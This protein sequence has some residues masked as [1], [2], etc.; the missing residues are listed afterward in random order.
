LRVTSRG[1]G[2]VYKRQPETELGNFSTRPLGLGVQGLADVYFKLGIPYDSKE[3]EKIN[4]EIFETLY[5]G[6]IKGSINE[7]KKD[8]SYPLYKDS[9]FSQGKFQ[10]DLASEFDGIDLNNYLSGRWDWDL[11]KQECCRYGIRNSMLVALMPTASSAQILNN[12]DCFEPIDANIYK[13]RTLSGDQL[14]MNKYLVNDLDKLGLWSKDMKDLILLHKGS[15]QQIDN[16]PKKLKDVYKTCW[17]ISMKAVIKQ[18]SDRGVFVDQMQSM[19][20]FMSNPTISKLTSAH[21]FAWKNKLK[22]GMYYLRSQ[23]S[24]QAANF[25]V[26]ATLEKSVRDK[27]ELGK[28]LSLEEE[29]LPVS[30][31]HLTLPTSP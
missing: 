14:I 25:G 16:I 31:T 26:D 29:V 4:K 15:I 9:P 11:L 27:Q 20:L 22:T 23:S 13:K 19:N 30:Y 17:E 2:D 28:Q 5:Y 1:L 12:S 3:A 6:C 10:F 24:V 21:F 7:A 18:A 8:G